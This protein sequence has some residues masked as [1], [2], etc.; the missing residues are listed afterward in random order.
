MHIAM[1]DMRQLLHGS[2]A[3]PAEGAD[4]RAVG[5]GAHGLRAEH[6]HLVPAAGLHG[7]RCVHALHARP[8]SSDGCTAC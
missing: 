8:H 2:D 3:L 4:N 1:P 6:A 7:H 5:H